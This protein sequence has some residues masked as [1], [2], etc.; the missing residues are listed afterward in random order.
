MVVAYKQHRCTYC[1]YQLQDSLGVSALSDSH[2]AS[3]ACDSITDVSGQTAPTAF[4]L[5]SLH[6]TSQLWP[7]S[8][9]EMITIEPL[10]P[11]GSNPVSFAEVLMAVI[12]H[13]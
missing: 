6:N 9:P 4:S 2:A 5:L 7:N 11:S 10:N 3:D 13:K 8:A 1:V 12:C